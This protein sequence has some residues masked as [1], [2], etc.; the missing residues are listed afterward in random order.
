ME[1]VEDSNE[2]LLDD[3]ERYLQ[4]ILQA[5]EQIIKDYKIVYSDVQDT[6]KIYPKF[7]VKQFNF[8]LGMINKRVFTPN[9]F[10]LKDNI[11]INRYDIHKV[12]LSYIVFSLFCT[13]YNMTYNIN[14]FCIFSGIE[15]ALLLEWLNTGK[16]KLY[17]DILE[18]SRNLD[19]FDMM[20]SK[21]ALLRLHYRNHEQIEHLE[22]NNSDTLPN[23]LLSNHLEKSITMEENPGKD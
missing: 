1:I 7:T 19:E 12:E 5:V 22:E 2:K 11:Y 21:N 3:T 23:L 17:L 4:Y 16:S 10:L 18:N 6:R 15:K 13:Y 20:N 8:V 9:K 14:M